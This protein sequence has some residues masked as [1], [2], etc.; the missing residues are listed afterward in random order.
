LSLILTLRRGHDF[1]VEDS[2]VVVSNILSSVS[3]NLRLDDGTIVRV[4]DQKWEALLPGVLVQ[5]GIPRGQNNNVI[6]IAID[7]PGKRILRGELYHRGIV[8]TCTTCK[9]V[10]TLT[11]KVLSSDGHTLVD[12]RFTCPDCP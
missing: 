11:Q 4:G 1:Y 3:F 6:R 9:G 7:A 8:K 5:A 2:R 10:G 12:D